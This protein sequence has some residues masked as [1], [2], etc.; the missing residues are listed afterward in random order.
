M[1]SN[2]ACIWEQKRSRSA[3]EASARRVELH[4]Q[5]SRHSLTLERNS[6]T[7]F[8]QVSTCGCHTRSPKD[9]FCYNPPPALRGRRR[10]HR[11]ARRP[12]GT[13]GVT[14]TL[15]VRAARE[16]GRIELAGLD[17]CDAEAVVELPLHGAE[18]RR[19][20][21]GERHRHGT[22]GLRRG[23]RYGVRT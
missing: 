12:P 23:H 11:L 17:W 6:A 22:L 1:N 19:V 9:D 16:I 8:T 5:T 4:H 2:G 10:V 13:P 15:R 20:V 14:V 7:W 21:E 3:M 18:R